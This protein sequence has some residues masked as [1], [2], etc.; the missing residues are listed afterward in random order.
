M[1][2]ACVSGACV[3]GACVSG[4]CVSGACVSVSMFTCNCNSSSHHPTIHLLFLPFPQNCTHE[5][6]LP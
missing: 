2:G 1:S 5:I 6:I 3:S 4:A